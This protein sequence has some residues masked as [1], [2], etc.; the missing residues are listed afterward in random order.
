M[1]FRIPTKDAGPAGSALTREPV[2]NR[3][4]GIQGLGVARPG[5]TP[6]SETQRAKSRPRSSCWALSQPRGPFAPRAGGFAAPPRSRRGML[7][8]M[9]SAKWR[10]LSKG[11]RDGRGRE[12]DSSSETCPVPPNRAG[13]ADTAGS[14]APE[15]AAMI[16]P[17]E[18]YSLHP[19][20][21][22]R[23]TLRVPDEP[24]RQGSS[25]VVS[26]RRQAR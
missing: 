4:T 17:G 1:A 20:E 21:H 11:P 26:S 6:Q 2:A 15:A 3:L 19:I 18:E 24:P 7:P 22:I 9:R 8:P 12:A 5:H 25:L 14:A 16:Q 13:R 10:A 23:P